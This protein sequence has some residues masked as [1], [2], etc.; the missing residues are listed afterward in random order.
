MPVL[1]LHRQAIIRRSSAYGSLECRFAAYLIDSSLFLFIQ[2]FA[3]YFILGYPFSPNLASEFF[4]P[5]LSIFTSDLDYLGKVIY[6]NIYFLILHWLYY[7]I[8]ESSHRQG[9]LGKIALD[10]KVTNLNGR[11]ITF[12]QAS[13]RY[14]AKFLSVGLLFGGFFVALFNPKHQTLHDIISGCVVRVNRLY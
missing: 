8:M 3:L 6:A 4:L 11:R 10:I 9:T 14:F 12:G 5:H 1:H 7:A 2:S 13:L